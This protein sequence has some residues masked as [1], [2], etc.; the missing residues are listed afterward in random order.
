[1]LLA[2]I[3]FSGF[4]H[5]LSKKIPNGRARYSCIVERI[6]APCAKLLLS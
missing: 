1:M 5:N 4:L 3:G 2:A 6:L